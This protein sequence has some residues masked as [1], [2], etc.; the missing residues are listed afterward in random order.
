VPFFKNLSTSASY[1]AS[2][3]SHNLSFELPDLTAHAQYTGGFLTIPAAP[4]M[5]PSQPLL[6]HIHL[7]FEA[8][9]IRSNDI[10]AVA[11]LQT[12][13]GGGGS[14]SAGGPGKG[15]YSRLYTHVLNQHS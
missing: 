12:L 6:T 2:V 10:Y 14:F 4:L 13:L 3:I 1:A 15:M 11:L 7:A 8:P 5:N 9:P